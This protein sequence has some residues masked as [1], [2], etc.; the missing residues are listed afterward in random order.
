MIEL[1]YNFCLPFWF[2]SLGIVKIEINDTLILAD[3][4]FANTKEEAIK[5]AK[6]MT[7]DREYL[8]LIRHL[9]FNNA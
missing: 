3:E 7:K 1:I 9:K 4:N 2:E 8:I 6:I 5:S